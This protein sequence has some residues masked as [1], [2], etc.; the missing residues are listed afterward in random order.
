MND[1]EREYTV[2]LEAEQWEIGQ[3]TP[4]DDSTDVIVAWKDGSRW[5]A[6]FVAYQHI[7]TLTEKNKR[8]GECL[9]GAYLWIHEMILIDKVSRFRIE[10]VIQYLIT[11]GEFH[12]VFRTL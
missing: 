8:T 12:Q 7:K 2:W 3:W 9:S 10:E 11:S 1:K 4:E 5:S 6:T